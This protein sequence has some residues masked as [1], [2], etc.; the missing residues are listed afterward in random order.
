MARKYGQV[1]NATPREVTTGVPIRLFT[2]STYHSLLKGA[3]EFV[4][5]HGRQKGVL[6]VASKKLAADELVYA[7]CESALQ[8]VYRFTIEQLV[9]E[10]AR[11]KTSENGLIPATP[12]ALQAMAA[13][14]VH[15]AVLNAGLSFIAPAPSS[16][17]QAAALVLPGGPVHPKIFED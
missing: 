16:R 2:S 7:H 13:R 4:V 17:A 10:I 11:K 6:I 5:R 3:G 12:M 15:A 1:A 9:H 14:A 8:G